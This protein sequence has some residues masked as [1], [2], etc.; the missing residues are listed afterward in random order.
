MKK[1]ELNVLIYIPFY[2]GKCEARH[3]RMHD[4]LQ[5]LNGI[6]RLDVSYQI[7]AERGKDSDSEK[8]WFNQIPFLK[9]YTEVYKYPSNSKSSPRD[10]KKIEQTRAFPTSRIDSISPRE[11]FSSDT[12][13]YKALRFAFRITL[14]SL[15]VTI[16]IVK[17]IKR[18]LIQRLKMA[19]R[20]IILLAKGDAYVPVWKL[21]RK[22]LIS[23]CSQMSP[24]DVLHIV[25]PNKTSDQLIE[26]FKQKNPNLRV[27]IGPNLMAYGHPSNGFS[28]DQFSDT[29]ITKILAVSSYHKELLENFGFEAEKVLRLPP[30]VHP[31]NFNPYSKVKHSNTTFTL[32][33]AASQLSVEKGAEEFLMALQKINESNI[34]D[35]K[36]IVI[37]NFNVNESVQTPLK[38]ELIN[39]ANDYVEFAGVVDR[40]D[41]ASYY[42]QA[43]V[44]VHCGEPENGPTTIIESL[45]CGTPC[46]LTNHLC[47]KEPELEGHCYFY[48]RGDVEG[49]I[50][51][52][53]EIYKKLDR[54]SDKKFLPTH[55]HQETIDFLLSAYMH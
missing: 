53:Q 28:F 29:A 27:V 46:L 37:G 55:T 54:Q 40:Q 20:L 2:S 32:L 25:R 44:F 24:C 12:F 21:C 9:K 49:L 11:V 1:Q 33:F 16:R 4:I 22:R 43:D 8:V 48:D 23:K 51:S 41:M 34:F 7:V 30:S 14:K 5:Y 13:F 31:K 18:S 47:F 35:F 19:V 38:K 6:D 26:I 10:N 52:L 15:R 39:A 36:A 50:N 42:S 17:R 3:A 45:S